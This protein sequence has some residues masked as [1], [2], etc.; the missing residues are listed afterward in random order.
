MKPYPTQTAL[1]SSNK[2]RTEE[3]KGCEPSPPLPTQHSASRQQQAAAE[4]RARPEVTTISTLSTVPPS[5]PDAV[6]KGPRLNRPAATA[7]AYKL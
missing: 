3:A 7:A 5:P 1:G 4:T 2:Q 6:A